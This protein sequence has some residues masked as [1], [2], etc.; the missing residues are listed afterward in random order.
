[1]SQDVSSPR[2]PRALL[3]ADRTRAGLWRWM[4]FITLV[5]FVLSLWVP[6]VPSEPLDPEQAATPLTLTNITLL[7]V[8]VALAVW[9][10]P[11]TARVRL[12]IAACLLGSTALAWAL[13]DPI[14]N[15]LGSPFALLACP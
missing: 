13:E 3:D 10:V 11:A 5:L 2:T 8:L 4:A 9:V 6:V 7:L 14:R 12:V 1:V 15:L